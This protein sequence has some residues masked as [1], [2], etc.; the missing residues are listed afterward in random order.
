LAPV[1]RSAAAPDADRHA[2][3][4]AEPGQSEGKLVAAGQRR[5]R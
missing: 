5:L 3:R 2:R 4:D 1:V